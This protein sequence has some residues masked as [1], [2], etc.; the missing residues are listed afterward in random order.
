MSPERYST[1]LFGEF[2]LDRRA[3]RLERNGVEIEIPPK[4]F[5]LLELFLQRPDELVTKQ[6][7]LDE[8]WREVAVVENTV[9]QRIREV[10]GALQDDAREPRYIETVPRKGY[11]FIADVTLEGGARIHPASDHTQ[12]N[13]GLAA[14]PGSASRRARSAVLAAAVTLT[15]AIV[16]AAVLLRSRAGGDSGAPHLRL[17][18]TFSGSHRAPAPSPDGRYI[19][20]EQDVD[21]GSQV[22]IAPLAGGEPLQITHGTSFARRPR[23]GSD[24]RI[25]FERIG[26]GIWAVAPL[27][28]EP[29]QLIAQGRNPNLSRDGRWLAFERPGE[30]WRSRSDGSE[31]RRI[32]ETVV[33]RL[34][35]ADASPALSPSGDRIAFFRQEAGPYGDLWVVSADGKV[36]RRLTEDGVRAGEPTFT[37][38][39]KAV[40][41]WSERGGSRTLWQI[42][43]SGGTPQALTTGSGHDVSPEFSADGRTLYYT[44]ARHQYRLVRLSLAGNE[45]DEVLLER[46]RGIW[47][48]QMSASGDRIV[49]FHETPAG[50]QVLT[51]P[52]AGGEPV[53]LTH[54]AEAPAIHPSWSADGNSIYFQRVAPP[55]LMR[56]SAEGG[57]P[58]VLFSDWSWQQQMFAWIDPTGARLVY[59]LFGEEG[60]RTTIVRELGSGSETRLSEPGLREFR[61]SPTG[62]AFLASRSDGDVVVC[63]V[64]DDPCRFVTVG[65]NATWSPDGS[66]VFYYRPSPRPRWA[67]LWSCTLDGT[68][69]TLHRTVGPLDPESPGFDVTADGSILVTLHEDP[70]H[71]LWRMELGPQRQG[72]GG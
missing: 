45:R 32:A 25:V 34:T 44:N 56:V 71:E 41:F 24:D 1:F 54:D 70:R 58:S 8:L 11:R 19:A 17:V 36:A 13:P 61:W 57:E 35:S 29:H 6:Q 26:Q 67:E 22:W 2:R 63:A 4:A 72:Q 59:P 49:F 7:L 12:A 9:P 69:E 47:L 43:V 62:D 10:R 38:D 66:R 51:L 18:S 33:R 20:F 16:L 68:E 53:Q 21:G 5:E 42:P 60:V 23:W 50:V 46:R 52:A 55:A 31:P 64:D 48:P 40:V 27:G 30:I 3:H 14:R 28:G 15:L 37:P 39:G 65:D